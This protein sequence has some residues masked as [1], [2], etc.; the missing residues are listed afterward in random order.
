MREKANAKKYKLENKDKARP[1]QPRQET[2]PRLTKN[3]IQSLLNQN[4]G[5][6][7]VTNYKGRNFREENRYK[8][9]GGKLFIRSRGK[10][11]WSDSHFDNERIADEKQARNF[12][13]K[14]F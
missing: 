8:I 2:K 3:R 5:F 11:S 6:E 1:R 12:F 4:E 7:A 10:T 13:K 14:V 9:S